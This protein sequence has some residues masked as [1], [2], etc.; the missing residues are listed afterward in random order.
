M[1]VLMWFIGNVLKVYYNIYN[2]SPIQLIIGTYVQVFCNIILISQIIYYYFTDI[3]EKN[4][5]LIDS[6]N[7][8]KIIFDGNN[9]ISPDN[10]EDDI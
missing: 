3:G 4:G 6:T 9:D 1:M 5:I 7:S 10:S 8:N 2:K